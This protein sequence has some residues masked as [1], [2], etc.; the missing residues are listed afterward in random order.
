MD[1]FI[2]LVSYH[3]LIVFLCK[4]NEKEFITFGYRAAFYNLD[5]KNLLQSSDD[6][7]K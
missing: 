5:N 7:N 1:A 3:I 6:I 2:T 4:V